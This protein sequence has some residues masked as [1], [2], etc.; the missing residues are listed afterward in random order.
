MWVRLDADSMM[1]LRW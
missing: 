1:C